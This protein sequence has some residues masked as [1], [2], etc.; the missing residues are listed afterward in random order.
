MTI[1]GEEFHKLG[2]IFQRDGATYMVIEARGCCTCD[3][4]DFFDE[5]KIPTCTAMELDCTGAHRKDYQD[6][7]YR[8]V[9]CDEVEQGTPA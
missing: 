1:L 6:V 9:E 8:R 4:C 3:G 7:I 5:T 2:E